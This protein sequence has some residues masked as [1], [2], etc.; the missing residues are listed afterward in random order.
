MRAGRGAEARGLESGGRR[1]ADNGGPRMAGD[2]WR[3]ADGATSRET[4]RGRRGLSR[5]AARRGGGRRSIDTPSAASKGGGR[6]GRVRVG[7][8]C[9]LRL[10]QGEGALGTGLSRRVARRVGAEW[11]AGAQVSTWRVRVERHKGAVVL[12]CLV[13]PPVPAPGFARALV[14]AGGGGLIRGARR[15]ETPETDARQGQERRAKEKDAREAAGSGGARDRAREGGDYLVK[16]AAEGMQGQSRE[17]QCTHG[18]SEV[19]RAYKAE[20]RHIGPS[21][22]G[23]VA[24]RISLS[25]AAVRGSPSRSRDTWTA[26]HAMACRS[27]CLTLTGVR[28]LAGG[29]WPGHRGVDAGVQRLRRRHRHTPP[30]SRPY[31]ACPP[32]ASPAATRQGAAAGQSRP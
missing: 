29:V 10:A 17:C 13:P 26:L 31:R 30:P 9:R 19:L 24:L 14:R 18:A 5:W 32:P 1:G 6:V 15:R 28:G 2:G 16:K 21:A 11:A 7:R 23:P 12:G 8:A 25:S 3:E 22:H 20:P 27:S 4:R